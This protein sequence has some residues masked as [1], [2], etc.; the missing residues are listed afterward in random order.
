VQKKKKEILHPPVVL[1]IHPLCTGTLNPNPIHPIAYFL[2][3][4]VSSAPERVP[5][6]TSAP[7][8]SRPGAARV[9]PDTN[10]FQFHFF[11]A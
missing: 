7:V 6:A 9:L 10:S 4:S 3:Y 2:F 11:N 8:A 1:Y 5:E